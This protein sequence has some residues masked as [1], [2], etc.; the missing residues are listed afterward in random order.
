MDY[1]KEI[2]SAFERCQ[3][4]LQQAIVPLIIYDDLEKRMKESIRQLQKTIESVVLSSE[5]LLN[6]DVAFKRACEALAS[7]TISITDCTQNVRIALSSLASSFP[8]L[9]IP[10]DSTSPITKIETDAPLVPGD[11][12]KK[13]LTLQDAVAILSLLIGLLQ[14]LSSA[15]DSRQ[16]EIRHHQEMQIKEE[17]LLLKEEEI[18][19]MEEQRDYLASVC[20]QLLTILDDSESTPSPAPT[21]ESPPP[22]SDS[23]ETSSP[24]GSKVAP[25]TETTSPL[26]SEVA[27]GTDS[28]SDDVSDNQNKNSETD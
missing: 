4:Q 15:I 2:L 11:S 16:A 6:C 18:C 26:E 27:P 28:S 10:S 3:H 19:L 21:L 22:T 14:M 1:Y 12:K 23:E 25:D 9:V 13:R 17:E 24:L 7:S 8:D 20:E 5:A